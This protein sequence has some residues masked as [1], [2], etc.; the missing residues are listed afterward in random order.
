MQ[1]DPLA[2]APSNIQAIIR[3]RPDPLPPR[4]T[5]EDRTAHREFVRT[6]GSNAV[7]LDY[8][9]VRSVAA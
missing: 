3:A 8:F 2:L 7:W 9:T 1:L 5:A 6:L 4:V